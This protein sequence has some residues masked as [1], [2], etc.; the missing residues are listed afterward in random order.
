MD[1][2]GAEV[3]NPTEQTTTQSWKVWYD[4]SAEQDEE[5]NTSKQTIDQSN[6]ILQVNNTITNQ[7]DNIATQQTTRWNKYTVEDLINK[8]FVWTW[9]SLDRIEFSN[10]S[11]TRHQISYY[12]NGIKVS[13]IMNIPNGQW[14]YPLLI[15]N[16]GYIDPAIYTVWRWLKREQNYLARQWYAVLHTD[17]RNHGL[18]DDDPQLENNYVFRNY[19]YATDAINAI[20]AVQERNDPRINT[21]TI[22]MLGHSMWGGVSMHASIAKPDLID[23]MILYAPVHSNEFFNFQRWRYQWLTDQEREELTKQL[24][25]L[26]QVSTFDQFSASENFDRIQ[27]P[28]Q[29]YH[30]TNDQSC[31]Y[32][33]SVQTRDAMQANH[34]N[35]ELITYD[36]EYHE[37]W[38]KFTDFM[39]TSTK[40]F[41]QHLKTQ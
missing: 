28:T 35:V 17:Y 33:R 9:L 36:G 19:F 24:G 29:I 32:Q 34:I 7:K 40:F 10:E 25:N 30:G 3:E 14:P 22:G 26:E 23:A 11:Y 8:N 37:F 20:V 18:S 4:Q 6:S 16:H 2:V 5:S 27:T 12:S 41:D 21:D 38:P 1:T 13:W 15:L 31:P 39:Q